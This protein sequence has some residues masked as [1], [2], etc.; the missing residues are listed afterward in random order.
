MSLK[1]Q[2]SIDYTLMELNL[3][4]KKNTALNLTI[5]Y[6]FIFQNIYHVNANLHMVMQSY[7]IICRHTSA[8]L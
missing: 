3:K 7:T 4:K 5:K 8:P 1:L 6:L 2:V